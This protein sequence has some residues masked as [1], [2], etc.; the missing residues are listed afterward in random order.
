MYS[1]QAL[2]FNVPIQFPLMRE[3]R[4]LGGKITCKATVVPAIVETYSEGE[5]VLR[6]RQ[7]DK[8]AFEK[9]YDDYSDAIYGL[10]LAILKDEARAEDAVQETFVRVWRKIH[11]YDAS[12]GR[13]F[14]WMLNIAR[15]HAI[16]VLRAEQ[17]RSA[18][19]TI[20]A[21]HPIAT[22]QGPSETIPIDN[23]GVR[24]FVEA[25]SPEQKSLVD[26]I[27]FQGYT[28][29]EAAE[30]LAIPLGT[31]KSRVRLAM[32]HLRRAMT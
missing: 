23:I 3:K 27:Y 22:T 19:D 31:V 1:P 14:T 4:Y 20:P 8:R 13:F 18:K 26:L 25:L 29:Q 12:K 21:E 16:D 2:R 24:A 10:S 15:N 17:S 9:L 11:S 30:V 5:M 7:Q 6:L 28:Q 32:N